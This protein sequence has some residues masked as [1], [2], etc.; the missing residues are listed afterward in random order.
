MVLPVIG[1]TW[2]VMSRKRKVLQ[3]DREEHDVKRK[4]DE[5]EGQSRDTQSEV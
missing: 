2:L 3:N 4:G 1:H 5:G